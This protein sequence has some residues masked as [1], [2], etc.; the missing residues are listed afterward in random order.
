MFSARLLVPLFLLLSLFAVGQNQPFTATLLTGNSFQQTPI[1][2]PNL[3]AKATKSEPWRII[4]QISASS[5]DPLSRILVAPAASS[6]MDHGFGMSF[7][8]GSGTDHIAI[9]L[10]GNPADAT[11]YSIRSYVVARDSKHSDSTHPVAYSTCQ[12]ANRY[13]LRNTVLEDGSSGQ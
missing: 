7:L 2:V 6:K 10:D 13:R 11:C 12:P 5:R 4:P 8:P 9:S 3:D 1:P